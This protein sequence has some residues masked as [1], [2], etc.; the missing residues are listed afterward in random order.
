MKNKKIVDGL[1]YQDHPR[2]SFYLDARTPQERQADSEIES[3]TTTS[4]DKINIS[5][6]LEEF[7][8]FGKKSQH[9]DF[10]ADK[11]EVKDFITHAIK[12]YS[13]A[14]RVKRKSSF[15]SDIRDFEGYNQAIS[16]FEKADKD[17]WENK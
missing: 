3:I 10:W 5:K 2:Q 9:Q 15:S 16:A 6:I 14:I 8:S 11:K 4:M 1:Y 13:E 7:D 12:L 17:F